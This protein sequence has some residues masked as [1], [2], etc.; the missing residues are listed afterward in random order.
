MPGRLSTGEKL[1][2]IFSTRTSWNT[3]VCSAIPVEQK[4]GTPAQPYR[5]SHDHV[6]PFIIIQ[7]FNNL[8]PPDFGTCTNWQSGQVCMVEGEA[9]VLLALDSFAGKRQ[10]ASGVDGA[11][12]MIRIFCDMI[13]FAP[14]SPFAVCLLPTDEYCKYFSRLTLYYPNLS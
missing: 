7:S 3:F 2:H 1:G 8:L 14:S 10:T 5:S 6:R 12:A 9:R 11:M 4:P 13:A